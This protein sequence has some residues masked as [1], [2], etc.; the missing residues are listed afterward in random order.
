MYDGH[1]TMD[2]VSVQ[3]LRKRT[4]DVL[5]RVTAGEKLLVTVDGR[6]VAELVP[7]ALRTVWVPRQCV[8]EN[9]VQADAALTKELA[10][11]LPDMVDE[12]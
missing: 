8:L 10:G 11:L 4:A 1:L 5:R 2:Y 7:L 9:L 6:P 3:E 12:L